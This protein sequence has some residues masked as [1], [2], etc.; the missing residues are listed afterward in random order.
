QANS[1]SRITKSH[2]SDFL[3]QREAHLLYL[4]SATRSLGSVHAAGHGSA[5]SSVSIFPRVT[6]SYT[7]NG[8]PL[9]LKLRTMPSSQSG[10]F[11]SPLA[12]L[13]TYRTRCPTLN[14]LL[15][16]SALPAVVTNH[17]GHSR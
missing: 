16:I 14:S 4:V 5:S 10:W 17:P 9:G 12:C 2:M 11:R 15:S 8:F 13:G 1:A 7:T 3:H 6:L